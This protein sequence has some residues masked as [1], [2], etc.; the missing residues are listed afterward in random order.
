M[1]APKANPEKLLTLVEEAYKAKIVL[2]EFQRSFVWSREDIEELLA[3]ILRGYFIGTFLMINT[4]SEEKKALFP[5]RPIEGLKTIN[6]EAFPGNHDIVRLVLDGQQRLTSLFYVLHEPKIPLRGSRSPYRFYLKLDFT[7]GGQLEDSICGISLNDKQGLSEMEEKVKKG[8]AI[9]FSLFRDAMEFYEWLYDSKKELSSDEIKILRQYYENFSDFMVP[10]ISISEDAGEENIINIFER[11][12]RTGIRLSLFDLAVARLYPKKINL[13]KLWRD[14]SE[15]NKTLAKIIK[16]EFI[17]KLIALWHDKEPK[18]SALLNI[19]DELNIVDDQK[20]QKFQKQWEEAC[21]WLLEAY[22]RLTSQ[23]GYGAIS[24]KWIPY[25]TL[26]VPLAVLL[27]KISEKGHKQEMYRKIDSWYWGSVFGRRYDQAVEST[28]HRDVREISEWLEG[29][30]CPQWIEKFQADQVDLLGATE[31]RSSIYRGAICLVVKMGAKDFVS[32]QPPILSQCQDD[33]IFPKG[34]FT[35]EKHINSVLNR[36]LIWKRSNQS[37]SNKK[38]SVYLNDLC[39]QWGRNKHEL[40]KIL[41]SHLI[42]EEAERAMRDDDFD[43]FIKARRENFQN[44]IDELVRL[45]T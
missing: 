22:K 36:T 10:V 30:P 11:I 39:E 3:S 20:D 13:R 41:D 24:P 37:K 33:H 40:R 2:P 43:T 6:P 25:T 23:E 18:K 38:P 9:P 29:G 44:K 28:T 14:F 27:K 19:A 4:K 17:L 31:Q 21:H 1:E 16:P 45:N 32:G 7:R 42:S 8:Q 5:Y 35:H 34:I 15:K 12:N 26:L